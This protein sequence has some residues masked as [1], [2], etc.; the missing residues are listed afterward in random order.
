LK[1]QRRNRRSHPWIFASEIAHFP[2]SDEVADGGMVEVVDAQGRFC[3]RGFLNRQSQIAVRY[4]ERA[5]D[6]PVDYQ[7]WLVRFQRALEHRERF[8][9]KEMHTFRWIH[10]EADG[11]P[12]LTVDRYGDVLVVQLL[13]L[14]LEPWRQVIVDCLVELGRPRTIYE[15]S[16]APVRRLEGMGE[17]VGLLWGDAPPDLVQIEEGTARLWV[18]IKQGQKTGLF[19]DQSLN[20]RH[21]ARFAAGRT[22]L[23]TFCYTGAFGVHCALAGAT[24]VLNV[25]ISDGAVDLARANGELNGLANYE[26]QL[27]NAFDLLREFDRIGRRF[28]MIILDPPAFAK[29]R[30]ALEGALR[31]YKEINLRAMKI[32]SPGGILVTCSCSS[33]LSIE[34]FRDVVRDAAQDTGRSA[35]LVEQRGQA[36]DHPILMH[37]PETEYLKYLL[38]EIT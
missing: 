35:C 21:A 13:A 9:G 1:P 33:H 23:N 30:S 15:R 5:A 10:G 16:D 3:G 18:D 31:G 37:I 19:L 36:P 8:L 17:Q 29:S 2:A 27:G 25:D 38:I 12:G 26:V 11:L 34:M 24:S 7:W 32:L 28:E 20:R 6:V 4:L 22:V 14:G